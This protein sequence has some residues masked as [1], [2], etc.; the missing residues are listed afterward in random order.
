MYENYKSIRVFKNSFLERLT[1]VHPITPLLVW[2]PVVFALI[3]YSSQVEHLS[4]ALVVTYG[5]LGFVS[6][7]LLEYVVHRFLFHFESEN[8][9]LKQ[10]HILIHGLHHMD[11]IDP[12]RLV[13]PPA[14]SLI[15][16]VIFYRLFL[17]LLGPI[18]VKPFFAFLVVGYLCYD[19]IHFAVHHFK[20]R[21]RFGR[22]LKTHHMLHH[23]ENPHSRF[24]V[25]SPFWDSVFGS[26]NS[27]GLDSPT[28]MRA[29]RGQAS[30]GSNFES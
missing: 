29:S 24:G 26:L 22:M 18:L 21:T 2:T 5:A 6:W 11:P 3:W 20:P 15:L 27:R 30:Q 7:T 12:T 14:G 25:S 10:I 16:G 9:K 4:W 23:F 1:H 13:L 28:V 8:P 19:Y 17:F